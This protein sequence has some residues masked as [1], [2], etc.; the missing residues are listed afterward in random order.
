M[1]QEN[2]EKESIV[3]KS[4]SGRAC[5]REG[6]RFYTSR[7]KRIFRHTWPLALGFA[8]LSA[9]AAA[10]PVL[11]SPT[12]LLPTL[13]LEAVAIILLLTIAYKVLVKKQLFERLPKPTDRQRRFPWIHHLG[14]VALVI[15]FSLLVALSLSIITTLPMLIVMAANWLNEVGQ[16]N[17]DP[18]GMPTYMTWLT[19]VVFLIAGFIQAYVWFTLL[20]P[21]YMMQ[22]SM[23]QQEAERAEAQA[24]FNTRNNTEKS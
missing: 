10:L 4:Q 23:A 16:L 15:I 9:M 24:K 3:L 21:I 14:M 11:I 19:L 12:L 5:I 22:G 2:K 1:E 18:D 20:G 6:F 7:F 8:V 17:G 13:L